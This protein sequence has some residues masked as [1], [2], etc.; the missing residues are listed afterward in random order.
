MYDYK[1]V[2]KAIELFKTY[3]SKK[4][5]SKILNITR[6]T[7]IRWINKYYNKPT[8]LIK[9]INTTFKPIQTKINVKNKIKNYIIELYTSNPFY[10]RKQ[11]QNL[12]FTNYKYKIGL[13][14]LKKVITSLNYTYKKARYLTIKNKNYIDDLK[15]ER[16][17]FQTKI[18]LIDPNKIISIDECGFNSI[19]ASNMK[20]HSIKGTQ[21][22]IPINEKK[23]KNNTLLM[24]LSTSTIINHEI[25]LN[26]INTNIFKN[27]IETT[28]KNNNLT[29]FVFLFDNVS[30]H[31]NDSI[32]NLIKKSGNDY[33]FTPPYSPNNNP[34]ENMFGIIKHEFTKQIIDDIINKNILSKKDF[35]LLKINKKMKLIEISNNKINEK[36]NELTNDLLLIKNSNNKLKKKELNELIKKEKKTKK[37]ELKKI[38]NEEKNNIKNELKKDDTSNIIKIYINKTIETIKKKYIHEKIIKIFI[39]AFNYDYKDIEK[40]IRDRIVFLRN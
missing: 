37:N 27:F 21:I 7:I 35:K 23:F 6:S 22:N 11:I 25:H 14:K 15:K 9:L 39:H 28:I 3:N 4:R 10:T 13:K 18:N 19:Y 16:S 2:L 17:K 38:K 40:E 8:N 33:M 5:V 29:N 26:K 32:L 1:I 20:G 12:I 24:A 36:K 30:F 34:I 31:K